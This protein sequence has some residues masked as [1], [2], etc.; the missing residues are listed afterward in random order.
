MG[1]AGGQMPQWWYVFKEHPLRTLKYL[2]TFQW[3]ML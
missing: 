2:F 1:P 3:H